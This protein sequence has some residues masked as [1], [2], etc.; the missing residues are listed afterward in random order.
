MV[1]YSWLQEIIA[2]QYHVPWKVQGIFYFSKT[3][4]ILIYKIAQEQKTTK[5]FNLKTEKILG[6]YVK[7]KV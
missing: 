4:A 3:K 1:V 2:K 5:L 7:M 6:F